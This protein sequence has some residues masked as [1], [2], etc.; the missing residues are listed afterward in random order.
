LIAQI[1]PAEVAAWRAD[2]ARTGPV[3]VDVREPWELAIC[4]IA[5]SVAM[6]M[7]ELPRRVEELPRERELVLVCHTGVRSAM[8]AAFLERLGFT[9]HN[10]RGG[11]AAWAQTVEPSMPRY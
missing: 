8:A 11:V 1:E 4:N 10:L 7:A 2:A 3:L 5:G 9:V 6:P